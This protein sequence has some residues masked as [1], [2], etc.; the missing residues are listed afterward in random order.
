MYTALPYMKHGGL[1]SQFTDSFTS[2]ANLGHAKL[3]IFLPIYIVPFDKSRGGLLKHGKAGA[4]LRIPSP[5]TIVTESPVTE[6]R[7]CRY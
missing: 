3:L 4:V 1:L 2:H 5:V 6:P 7:F